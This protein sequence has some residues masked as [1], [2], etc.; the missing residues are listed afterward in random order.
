MFDTAMLVRQP[1]HLALERLAARS[2]VADDFVAAHAYADRR[3]RIEPPAQAHCF[4]LRAEA[5]WRLGRR[6]AALADLTRAIGIAPHDIGAL[7]RIVAWG[8]PDDRRAAAKALLAHDRHPA[9]LRTAIAALRETGEQAWAAFAVFDGYV[10]G[11]V[12]W[13]GGARIEARLASDDGTLTSFLGPNAL[14]PLAGDDVQATT[15]RIRRPL[16]SAPQQLTL[17]RDGETVLAVRMKPNTISPLDRRPRSS[18]S[19]VAAQ[20]PTVIVPVYGDHDATRACLESLIK[21]SASTMPG[22]VQS[23]PFNVLVI[24]DA[25]PEP[26]LRHYVRELALDGQIELLVNPVNLGFVGAVNRALE[27][28]DEGDVVLLNADTVVPP[29]F[30]ERLAA[31]AHS[32]PDIGTVTPLSNNGEFFSFPS[33]NSV[34]PL[35]AYDEIIALDRAAARTNDGV[36]IEMPSGIGFCLFIKR[37]CLD[38]LGGLSESFARGYLEDVD[39]CLRA[40]AHGFRNVC[41]SSVYVGHH[42]S[43]SFRTEKRSL[44]LRN[45]GVLEHRFPAYRNECRAFEARDPLR[46]ARAAIEQAL[47]RAEKPQ[48]LITA[49]RG[50]SLALAKARAAQLEQ[51]GRRAIFLLPEGN[52]LRLVAA[53]GEAPQSILLSFDTAE[54]NIKA[55][56]ELARLNITHLEQIDVELSP[57]LIDLARNL[58]IKVDCWISTESSLEHADIVDRLLAPS[59][60]AR[61]FALARRP[62]LQI[63]LRPWTIAPIDLPPP[64]ADAP[65]SLA[66]V[67]AAASV[68]SWQAIR[69]LALKFNNAGLEVPI[70]VAGET[71]DDGKL[72]SFPGVFVTGAVTTDETIE[73]LTL[74]NP[75]WIVTDFEKPL[76][77]HP[78]VESVRQ[79]ARPV[80]YRDWTNGLVP[81][82]DGDLAIASEA[83]ADA[84]SAAIAQWIGA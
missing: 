21:A 39:L 76:F 42:G 9:T 41:A 29:G 8:E 75:G 32:A 30:V 12:A 38:R 67:P 26:E 33:P 18:E 27:H 20:L 17:E 1:H 50:V 51:V 34:N 70:V 78:V 52:H 55:A 40:R 48:V 16:S 15:F 71:V 63:E 64:A 54:S 83:D 68:A 53:D 19:S 62:E 43:R 28:V 61:S 14:H 56:L 22:G 58:D 59:E 24:D 60:A 79:M 84:F 47:P 66:I 46:P 72:M 57:T 35:P 73:A 31:I 45:L 2:L 80:A 36:I 11:W 25:S 82:R 65:R 49:G 23:Q 6:D 3:C 44:V 10:S 13:A 4:V 7:R 5:A 81:P 77:G 37:E 69:A 74:H